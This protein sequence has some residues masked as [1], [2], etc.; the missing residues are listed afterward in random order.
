MY[1]MCVQICVY[2]YTHTRLASSWQY[3]ARGRAT[4]TKRTMMISLPLRNTSNTPPTTAAGPQRLT[5][6]NGRHP[7]CSKEKGRARRRTAP[8]DLAHSWATQARPRRRA[9]ARGT[10]QRHVASMGF[11]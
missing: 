4:G 11:G 8:T 5:P 7:C 6:K 1:G 10:V 3:R 2:T 9:W